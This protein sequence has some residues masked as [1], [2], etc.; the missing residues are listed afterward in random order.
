[1]RI[2]MKKYAKSFLICFLLLTVLALIGCE[3][4]QGKLIVDAKPIDSEYVVIYSENEF[5]LP[6]VASLR[7]IGCHIQWTD[8]KSAIVTWEGQDYAL[9]ISEEE[10]SFAK[11][12]DNT[13]NY[14][15]PAPGSK[16]YY[17]KSIEKDIIIDD[18]TFDLIMHMMEIEANIY[19]DCNSMT[20]YVE[21]LHTAEEE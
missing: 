19:A 13:V 12:G 16:N 17:F 4:K 10:K 20:A 14:L 11:I 3:G 2:G 9:N 18:G 15:L 5:E 6:L 7:S 21:I 1:M 8:E